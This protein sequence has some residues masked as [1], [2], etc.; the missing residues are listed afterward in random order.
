VAHV[1]ALDASAL[2]AHSNPADP[3]HQPATAVLLAGTPGQMLAHTMGVP[4]AT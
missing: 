1:T 2:I 4:V 3:H